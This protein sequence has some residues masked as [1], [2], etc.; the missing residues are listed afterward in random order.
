MLL[1]KFDT[2]LHAE[3]HVA[4]SQNSPHT[5]ICFKAVTATL[6]AA[7]TVGTKRAHCWI[8]QFH[9]HCTIIDTVMLWQWARVKPFAFGRHPV[10][11]D[12]WLDALEER[13][14]AGR[15]SSQLPPAAAGGNCELAL[16][17]SLRSSSASSQTSS[18][19]GCLPKANGFTRAHCH[20]ITVSIIVQCRWNCRIQQCALFVPTVWAALNVAVTALKQIWVWGEFCESATCSSAWSSVSNFNSNIVTETY[21]HMLPSSPTKLSPQ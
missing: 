12:V 19:T 7:H 21:L 9:L 8:L 4:L 6:S 2:E 18:L 1:L 13:S 3:E 11:L 10:K 14:E 20:S 15:A 16:P 5:Q 17:A